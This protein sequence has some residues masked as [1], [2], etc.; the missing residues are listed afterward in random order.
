VTLDRLFVTG[1]GGCL[2]DPVTGG[3][4]PARPA[5]AALANLDVPLVL[6][7][8]RP[9]REVEL[10][11]RLFGL[12]TPMIVENG[13]ALVVPDG[14]L[15]RGVPGGRPER[16][17]QVLVLGPPRQRLR[18][19][20][21]EIAAAARVEVRLVAD[22]RPGDRPASGGGGWAP[23]STVHDYVDPF[24]VEREQDA[25][26]LAREAETRGLRVARG[27]HALHLLGGADKG[28][29]LRTLLSLYE[30]EGL[31]PRVVALGAWPTDL[32]MLRAAHR[33]IVLPGPAGRPD[34]QLAAGLPEAERARRGGPEGW[35]DAVLAVLTGRQLPA[36]GAERA[37]CGPDA[38]LPIRDVGLAARG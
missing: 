19:A 38:G 13:A 12:A 11:S 8:S 32:P 2:V 21:A 35:N 25:V 5:V 28:L 14:H 1:I 17:H 29:A 33:P 7:S 18:E 20:L 9:R 24:L 37:P 26:A 30:R 15:Q 27:E 23:S 3:C 22:L 34:P 16:E 36:A 31:R 4:D 6:C 10:V